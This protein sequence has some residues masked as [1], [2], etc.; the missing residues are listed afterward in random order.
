MAIQSQVK[1]LLASKEESTWG[2]AAG[3]S[4]AQ[5]MRHVSSSLQVIKD[6]YQ[7]NEKRPDMQVYDM[8]HGF[9]RASGAVESEL[10][11][12]TYDEWLQALLRGTWAAGISKGNAE[13]TSAAADN[14]TSKFTMGGGSLITEGF[15]IGDVVIFTGLSEALNNNVNYI[16][17]SL[18]ATDMGVYPAPTDM[19]ADA[20]FTVEVQGSKLINGTTNRSF[21]IEQIYPDIDI[22][23][24]MT[25]MRVNQ[26]QFRLPPSGLATC[27]WDFMGKDGAVASGGSA[28][29]F[30]SPTAATDTPILAAVSGAC[31]IDG[32]ASSLITGIDFTATNNMTTTPV[33]GT[34][35]APEIFYG[36]HVTTGTVSMYVE[37]ED[38]INYF[39]NESEIAI[40][41]LMESPG[42]TPKD[43][44]AFTFPRV[45]LSGVQKQIASE[46][47][48]IASFPFQA[49]LKGAADG[50]DATS[51]KIQRSN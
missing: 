30:S 4:G 1:V 8:R 12:A 21:T 18:T 2:T 24:L 20:S 39:L 50:Y 49:L 31:V 27:T 3:A 17:T 13:F 33:V 26:G 36:R 48:V 22:N 19:T 42:S 38:Q 37:S 45:K 43:F 6:T 46:G 34:N 41:V 47:G 29:Y 11:V 28:P 23:E 16:I 51:W 14:A 44:L 9:R 7:S 10:S 40:T 32:V 35:G 5:Y 15:K 25:G